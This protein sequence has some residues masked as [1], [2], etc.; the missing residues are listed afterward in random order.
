MGFLV[1]HHPKCHCDL[2]IRLDNWPS[3]CIT[4]GNMLAGDNN[5]GEQ[6]KCC[7]RHTKKQA[8]NILFVHG[9]SHL[10][11]TTNSGNFSPHK[12][13]YGREK[14]DVLFNFIF[15]RHFL[16][17]TP[18]KLANNHERQHIRHVCS[19]TFRKTRN[20]QRKRVMSR[21]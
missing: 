14:Y 20:C 5:L 4:I 10:K 15:H 11:V 3:E 13:S 1:C 21:T 17:T 9:N 2:F 7:S 18:K 12:Q 16:F 6:L 8:K 19:F